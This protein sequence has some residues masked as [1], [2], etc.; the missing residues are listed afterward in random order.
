MKRKGPYR[1]HVY[2]LTHDEETRLRD[3]LAASGVKVG[4]AKGV[5][6]TPLDRI[7]KISTV[8][9]DVWND[10]CGRQ[11]SW[12][13]TSERNSLYLVVS[14]FEL[15]D[16]EGRKS[17]TLSESDFVPSRFASLEEKKALFEDPGIRERI[18]EEWGQVKEAEK[19]IYLRWA[20]RLGSGIRDYDLL[21]L[22]H[23]ANHGNF[24]KP[25]FFIEEDGGIIP[26]SIDRSAHLC[27][28]CLELFQVLGSAF[29]KKLV[30]PCPGATIFAR[31]KPDRYLL[32]ER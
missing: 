16:Y 14:S 19:R 24:I 23:T 10:T 22:S 29:D 18:P 13:R 25:R 6:C 27:S 15:K 26:Y 5:V 21:Y 7:N 1:K 17:A 32:V 28:C 30:A 3:E 4:I 11:G 20:R 9:P 8:S 31:L 12:Y 2:W